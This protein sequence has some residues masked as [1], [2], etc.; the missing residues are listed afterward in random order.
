MID[1]ASVHTMPLR[2]VSGIYGTEIVLLPG[3]QLYDIRIDAGT[4]SLRMDTQT[5]DA[6]DTYRHTVAFRVK[7]DR[8][9]QVIFIERLR[10]K[11]VHLVLVDANGQTRLL[12]NMR[13]GVRLENGPRG[14]AN[15]AQYTFTGTDSFP[16]Q[17]YDGDI[18]TTDEVIL[19]EAVILSKEGEYYRLAVGVCEELI[20]LV[21]TDTNVIPGTFRVADA[22]GTT[23]ALSIDDCG[24]LITTATA[25]TAGQLLIT[26]PTGNTYEVTVGTCGELITTRQGNDLPDG[27]ANTG[28]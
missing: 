11:R 26:A 7:K 5:S 12:L 14:D 25:G 19:L 9:E 6:G 20:T 1:P 22:S 10:N 17:F 8:P 23:Y 4:G 2:G 21:T 15:N 24:E 3:A 18:A 13:M 27:G 16:Y 28:G